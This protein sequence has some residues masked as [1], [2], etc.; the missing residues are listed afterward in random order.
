[1]ALGFHGTGLTLTSMIS[2]S[3]RNIILK[4]VNRLNTKRE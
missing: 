3:K 2:N 1:M 4:I